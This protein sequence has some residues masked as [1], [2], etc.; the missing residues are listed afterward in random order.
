MKFRKFVNWCESHIESGDW[1]DVRQLLEYQKI[2][3][4]VRK[5]PF[6]RR[7]DFWKTFYEPKIVKEITHHEMKK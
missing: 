7:E 1:Y 4:E 3:F 5:R 6:W 2:I